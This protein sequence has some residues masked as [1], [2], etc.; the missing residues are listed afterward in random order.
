MKKFLSKIKSSVGQKEFSYDEDMPKEFEEDYVELT[1]DGDVPKARIVV[2][3]FIV[4]DFSDIKPVL[5]SL[6]EG[7]TIALVNIGPLRERDMIELKRAVNKLKKTCDAIDGDIA[8]FGGDW[9]VVTPSF[10]SVHRTNAMES[11]GDE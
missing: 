6:R 3:P 1:A 7:Y 10:A 8:G 2:R 11:F 5:D 9:I 4:Q